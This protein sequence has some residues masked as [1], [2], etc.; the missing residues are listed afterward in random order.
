MLFEGEFMKICPECNAKNFDT[1]KI[2]NK[3][4]SPI[5]EKYELYAQI[6]SPTLSHAAKI[7]MISQVASVVVF[8][9]AC[10]LI[11]ILAVALSNDYENANLI[12]LVIIGFSMSLPLCWCLPMTYHYCN[13]TEKGI[14]VGLAFKICT[15][16]FVSLIAGI[17]MLFNSDV[18]FCKKCGA[19]NY[20]ISRA[21][22]KCKT[23][24]NS[25]TDFERI[26]S[27]PAVAKVA[28]VFMIV[29]F[30]MFVEFVIGAVAF[31]LGTLLLLK[32][33]SV[34][35]F[36]FGK[37]S[38]L[39]FDF[40]LLYKFIIFIIIALVV[41]PF[42]WYIPMIRIYCKRIAR[43]ETVSVGFK[44]C[45]LLFISP[46]AGILMLCDNRNS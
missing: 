45:T 31:L 4:G 8:V 26:G 27:V 1:E 33:F 15:L 21:C 35:V 38:M 6:K 22:H 42:A 11:C 9:L 5:L 34:L 46:I 37:L 43:G 39:L 40:L 23:P 2:C 13:R 19:R 29:E 16:L 20:S 28:N 44:V 17:M 7:V 24:I 3:C 25:K 10:F 41:C 30:A 12:P 18:A 36:L 32:Q 14:P